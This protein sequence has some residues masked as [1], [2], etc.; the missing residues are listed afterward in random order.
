MSIDRVEA[1]IREIA[2]THGIAVSRN[3]PIMILQTIN[4][5]LL[6]DSAKAQHAMLDA[7]KEELEGLTQQW[8]NNAKAM[9]DRVLNASLS[10][11]KDAMATLMHEGAKE[12]TKS[13]KAEVEAGI[14]ASIAAPVRD[15]RRIAIF[16]VIAAVMTFFAAG[17]AL[18]ASR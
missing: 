12:L 14:A 16:N 7:Y 2:V 8:G 4:M 13:V 11:S 6:D 9:A 15:G 1:L 5:R 3:D 18:W 10:A 17:L